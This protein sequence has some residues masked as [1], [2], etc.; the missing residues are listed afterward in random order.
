[1][2]GTA[3]SVPGGCDKGRI[4]RGVPISHGWARLRERSCQ[5]LGALCQI[6]HA[7]MTGFEEYREEFEEGGRG[8]PRDKVELAAR[9]DVVEF[10]EANREKVFSSR[11]MEVHFEKRT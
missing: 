7:E 9:E 10:I 2:G 1:M 6:L 8:K 5:G 11:Q 3:D 4:A